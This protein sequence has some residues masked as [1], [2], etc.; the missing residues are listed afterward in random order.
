M[1]SVLV[2]DDEEDVRELVR[3][4]QERDGHRVRT[5]ADGESALRSIEAETPD[6]VVLDVMMPGLDGW[7]VLSRLKAS[8]RAEVAHV[9][10]VLLTAR[11]DD[12]DRIRGGIEG[13]IHYVTK[14]FAVQDLRAVVRSTL[15]GE[16]EPVKR[17]RVQHDALARLARLEGGEPPTRRVRAARP[18]LTKLEPADRAKARAPRIAMP[19][20]AALRSLSPKQRTLLAA[21][22][23]NATVRAAAEELQVSRSNVYASLRRIARRLDVGSVGELV[24]LA[25]QGGLAAAD[26]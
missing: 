5:V 7:G 12:I 11:T 20:A 15:E 13:A 24:A 14:P 19:S 8:R 25:R 9:P 18:R 22:G 23:R 21:V 26:D 17:K 2:V 6:V 1:A 10:V 3:L 4:N 16:P